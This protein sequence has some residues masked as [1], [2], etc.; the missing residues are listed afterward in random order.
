[1]R[2]AI[3]ALERLKK[4]GPAAVEKALA[5]EARRAFAKSQELVPV[6]TGRLKE[7]GRIEKIETPD[8]VEYRIRYGGKVVRGVDVNY[9]VA[10]HELPGA[11]RKFL[12]RSV[13]RA[14]IERRLREALHQAIEKELK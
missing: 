3:R 14:R 13:D 7:S 8:G 6:V 11:G 2:E 10:V 4:A 12:E 1:L 5:E 9:A